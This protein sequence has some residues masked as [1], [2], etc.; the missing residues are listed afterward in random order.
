MVPSSE[1]NKS[2]ALL[3]RDVRP[4][5]P[6]L[7]I[8]YSGVSS[9]PTRTIHPLSAGWWPVQKQVRSTLPL[10]VR[11][12]S[13]PSVGWLPQLIRLCHQSV[14]VQLQQPQLP[15]PLPR[16]DRHYFVV[17][18]PCICWV[19]FLLGH[20]KV[21]L[22]GVIPPLHQQRVPGTVSTPNVELLLQLLQISQRAGT[23]SQPLLV[24]RT[25]L[26]LGPHPRARVL[27]RRFYLGSSRGH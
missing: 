15:K 23:P 26:V 3:S 18:H 7:R 21:T 11:D 1:L 27:I 20:A 25:L 9:L 13:Y 17:T 19:R 6:P 12:S 5:P 24:F 4:F 16:S 14:V 22:P 8:Q 2:F 10:L